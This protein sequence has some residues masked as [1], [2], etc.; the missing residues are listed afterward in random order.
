MVLCLIAVGKMDY[1]YLE[2]GLSPTLI[3]QPFFAVASGTSVVF[4][5]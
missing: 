2:R 4:N 1:F 5:G 3:K